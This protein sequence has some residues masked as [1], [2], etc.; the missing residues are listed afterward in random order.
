MRIRHA[1]VRPPGDSYAD[2]LTSAALGA[3]DLPLALAQHEAYCR[4]LESCGAAVTWLDAEP[5]FP[6]S[7][8]VED[9]AVLTAAS[10][11]LTRPGAPS[12]QGEVA[13]ISG[14]LSGFFR[15]LPRIE[16]PGTLEGGD[17][18]QV[19]SHFFLGLSERT[20]EEGAR[21]LAAL[22]A[23]EGLTAEEIDIRKIPG[24]LHLK[25][26][27]SDLGEGRLAAIAALADHPALSGREVV[28]VEEEEAYAA[29]C[30]RVNGTVLIAAGHPR[31]A[32]A[33]A[34]QGYATLALDMS[35][36]Q[37]MDGGLSCLSLRVP[38]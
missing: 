23:A 37:K 32:A 33:L 1:I 26:G 14:V 4:A 13:T 16:P 22:L 25:S 34:R 5:R 8:F 2:G 6:D 27:L 9:T 38:A 3:P 29:N 31:F 18:C 12:R 19:G 7:T 28:H 11:V 21:Q 17:I 24:L 30:I 15:H 35:E 20:N 10:A 36:F